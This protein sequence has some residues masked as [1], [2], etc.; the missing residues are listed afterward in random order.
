MDSLELRPISDADADLLFRIYASSRA[1]EMDLVPWDE[2]T[3][4][5]FLQMQFTAQQAHYRANFPRASHDVILAGG[6]PVGQLYVDR[7]EQEIR[8]LDIA[9]LP[10]AR[11]GGIGLHFL[12]KLMVEAQTVQK[13]LS[14]YIDQSSPSLDLFQR[15]GFVQAGGNGVSCLME[16]Q[17][18]AT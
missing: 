6:V 18:A 4:Q 16:W 11:G 8:I 9:L 10:K 3:K 7:R 1:E 5:S 13:T 2:A 17:P 12:R 14:I 15:L